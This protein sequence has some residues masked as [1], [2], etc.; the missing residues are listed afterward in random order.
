MQTAKTIGI[1]GHPYDAATI[2]ALCAVLDE[3]WHSMTLAEQ[4]LTPRSQIAR[5]LLKAAAEGERNPD[6]LRIRARDA[7][8]DVPL[9]PH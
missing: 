3:V 2:D 5:R 7:H 8:S 6:V 9:R 1:A 4:A